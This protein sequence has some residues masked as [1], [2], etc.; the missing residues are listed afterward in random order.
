MSETPDPFD[1]LEHAE[2][3]AAAVMNYVFIKCGEDGLRELLAR[4]IDPDQELLNELGSAFQGYD[5]EA[6]QRDVAELLEMGLTKA[7]DIVHEAAAGA[8]SERELL[9]PY[10]ESDRVNY[11]CWQ[12]AY[13]RRQYRRNNPIGGMF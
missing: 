11:Q 10:D 1:T 13:D 8:L 4:L 3:P 9:C 7:A 6:L 2:A 5:R 12:Q